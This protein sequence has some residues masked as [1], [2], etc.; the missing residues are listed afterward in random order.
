[1]A[2]VMVRAATIFQA[3]DLNGDGQLS[4]GELTHKFSAG[5]ADGAMKQMDTDQDGFVSVTE[6]NRFFIRQY[7]AKGM[8]AVQGMI[9]NLEKKL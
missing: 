3:V 1:M 2:S 9:N 4:K 6:W 7:N 8:D 5:M